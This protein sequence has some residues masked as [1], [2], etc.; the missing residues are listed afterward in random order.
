MFESLTD[1]LGSTLRNLRG[2]GKLTEENMAESLQEVRKALLAADVHFRV[3]R[4]FIERVREACVGQEVLKS[5]S[6]GQMVVKVINDE[7]AKLLGEGSTE[8]V[9][10]K[11]LRVLLLGLQGSGKT[12]FA[13]K[14]AKRLEKEGYKPAL[15]ACDV[16]RPA[17]IDQLEILAKDNGFLFYG[18]RDQKDVVGISK[19]GAKWAREQGATA[20]IFDTAG[21]LQIDTEL[22]EEVRKVRE[23]VQP[24]ES[25]LVADA[26]LGQEA[27]NVAKTFNE[28]VP[29]TGIVMTKLDG[30]TRGGAAL[31]MKS[32]TGVPIKFLGV[33]EKVTDLEACHPDRLAGRILGMGDVVSLVEKAQENIDEKEAERMA[34]KL[35]TADFNFEDFLSQM[36]QVKKM[37]SLGGLM[38]MIPGM[39]NMQ[40]GDREERKMKH[41][42]AL[43]QSMTPLERSNPVIL[44]GSRRARIAQGAG[45]QVKDL[46]ALIKQFQQMKKM[47]KMM[48]G[49]KGRKMMKKFQKGGMQLPEGGDLGGLGG[50]KF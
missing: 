48:K 30:D 32:I 40:V 29:L 49:G 34:K 44:N 42:E 20:V 13:A 28:S 38:K 26:A 45:L 1:R 37:G 6:P 17:A 35:E 8:L 14:L 10:E 23:T 46:N 33:G 18:E 7:L 2:K 43:I 3:A 16:Y 5:V 11:P 27:V 31:S 12:T 36:Q 39:N 19:R 25:L 4:E 9:N 50:M 41:T 47:M 15:I 24:Q 22:V 21:R